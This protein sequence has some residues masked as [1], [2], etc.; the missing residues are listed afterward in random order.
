MLIAAIRIPITHLHSILD[1]MNFIP[2]RRSCG[3]SWVTFWGVVPGFPDGVSS[4]NQVVAWDL[5][6]AIYTDA[7]ISQAG[8][9]GNGAAVT[10]R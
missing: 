7:N 8:S 1:G 9:N 4:A 2:R 3:L 10:R 6:T 5:P